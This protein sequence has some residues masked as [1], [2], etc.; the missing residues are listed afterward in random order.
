MF[1]L[2]GLEHGWNAATLGGPIADAYR[3]ASGSAVASAAKAITSFD[4]G[5]SI[6]DVN[7]YRV[8]VGIEGAAGAILTDTGLRHHVS[9]ATIA[10]AAASFTGKHA[11]AGAITISAAQDTG[12]DFAQLT[13]SV[14]ET[15]SALHVTE[16]AAALI[17]AAAALSHT[18][19]ND[20]R[21]AYAHMNG[22]FAGS[23]TDAATV[24][25]SY[26]VGDHHSPLPLY[27]FTS[28]PGE[29]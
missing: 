15:A 22:Y 11:L 2:A 4:L 10:A 24:F 14:R 13:T 3:A 20:A 25:A 1:A 6:A 27:L 18:P 7:A 19:V 23:D 29:D 8:Q 21:E 28:E 17:V 26:L 5:V 16:N 9:A 12:I